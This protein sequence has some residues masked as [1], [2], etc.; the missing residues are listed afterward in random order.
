MLGNRVHRR[1]A[2]IGVRT[3]GIMAAALTAGWLAIDCAAAGPRDGHRV[4]TK[5]ATALR[6]PADTRF[7]GWA[8][9]RVVRLESNPQSLRAVD[10]DGDGRHRLI[11]I[12]PRQ[13]RLEVYRWLP[14]KEREAAPTDADRPN[15]LPMA[16]DLKL[17]E[18]GLDRLP[19]DVAAIDLDGDARPELVV[20]MTPPNQV[21]ALKR[22]GGGKWVRGESWDLLPGDLTGRSRLMLPR[23]TAAGKTELLISFGDGIQSLT[24]E[25]D[26]RASWLSPRERKGRVDWWLIDPDNDRDL[27]L[28]EWTREARQTVRWYENQKQVLLPA[29]V[30]FDQPAESVDTTKLPDGGDELLL[31]GGMQSGLLRRYALGRGEESPLGGQEVLPLSGADKPTWC[32]LTIHQT[33][34]LA[35]VDPRQPRLLL[36]ALSDGTWGDEQ[37]YPIVN[38]VRAVAAAPT[39]DARLLLWAKDGGDVLVSRWENGRM[40]YPAAMGLSA[41]VEDRKLLA[42]SSVGSTVW[43]AQK[44]GPDVDLYVWSPGQE[45]ALRTRFAGVGAKA[46]KVAWIGPEQPGGGERVLLMEQFARHPKLVVLDGEKAVTSEPAQVKKLN[47]DELSLIEVQGRR[48]PARIADGVLQWLN[49]ASLEATDQVMLP[50]GAKLSGYLPLGDRAAWALEVGGQNAH[51]LEADDAG[52]M[53]V[54]QTVKLPGGT[55]LSMDPVLGLLLADRER[56]ISLRPGRAPELVLEESIDSRAG[57]P[58]GVREATIH[59]VFTADL[60][61]DGREEVVLVDDFRHQLTVMSRRD[62]ELVPLASWTVYEDKAYPYGSEFGSDRPREQEPRALVGLDFDG[63]RKQDLA[64]LCHDRL[65]VYLARKVQ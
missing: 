19:R 21:V 18:I 41:E 39:G 15:D 60:T 49:P 58:S 30:L 10:L 51:R 20:L 32:G 47:I 34:M 59:R 1:R 29:R 33:K 4:A 26:A 61:G 42:L 40:T 45:R 5:P 57:R 8:A 6:P 16:T 7:P 13:A 2:V 64:M 54:R 14:P 44:V 46:D 27:D 48:R 24:L 37:S 56:L 3:L 28:V 52:V 12:D 22:D 17:E 9:M 38:D 25:K 55:A 65:I 23:K 63:D 43:W 31:L 11:A 62:G 35:A 53:R 50:E 36:Y